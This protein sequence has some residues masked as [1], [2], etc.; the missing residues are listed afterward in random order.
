[1]VLRDGGNVL[2]CA[3]VWTGHLYVNELI[4]RAGAK[5]GHS[6]GSSLPLSDGSLVE[7]W[8]KIQDERAEPLSVVPKLTPVG[9]GFD[10]WPCCFPESCSC[11]TWAWTLFGLVFDLANQLEGCPGFPE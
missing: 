5:M 6:L 4:S 1:M 8:R 7:A 2:I 10:L 9:S 3:V 11:W